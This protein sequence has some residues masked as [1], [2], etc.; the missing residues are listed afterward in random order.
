[1]SHDE[2]P[3]LSSMSSALNVDELLQTLT[4]VLWQQRRLLERVRYHLKVQELI[5]AGTDDW[6]LTFAVNDVE[7]VMRAVA[8]V[9]AARVEIT[10]DLG[11]ALGLG[12]NPSLQTLVDVAPEPYGPMLDEH[13]AAF[14]ELAS[15]I[16]S[17]SLNGRA[18]LQRGLDLTKSL[19]AV[20]FGDQGDGG[21]DSSGSV[22]RGSAERRLVDRSL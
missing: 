7:D 9:E 11:L 10:Q 8:E 19:S 12:A 4:R 18:Q 17:V 2:L 22:V 13:R 1:M 6:M 14:L 20:V 16:T 3:N 15:E 21:Y 5:L